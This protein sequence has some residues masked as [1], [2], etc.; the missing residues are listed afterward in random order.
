VRTA[1]ALGSNIGDRLAHLQRARDEIMRIPDVR[2]PLLSSRVFETEPIDCSADAAPF[3]NAVIEVEYEGE[4]GL[5]LAA[6]HR[7]EAAMGRPSRRPRNAPRT[8]DLD[9]L[10]IGGRALAGGVLTLPHPRIPERRFVLAPLAD[11]RP[12]LVL[13]GQRLCVAELL[14]GL[15]DP[16]RVAVFATAW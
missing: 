11:V 1:I 6:L 15:N 12:E 16:A 13:P 9:I 5:L 4:P 2:G 14:A 7:I 10:S 3:L 8:I